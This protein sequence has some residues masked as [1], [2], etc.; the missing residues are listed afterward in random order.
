M[1]VYGHVSGLSR[2]VVHLPLRQPSISPCA[3]AIHD[4]DI[5]RGS[6]VLRSDAMR[7]DAMYCVCVACV[8]RMEY[9]RSRKVGRWNHGGK[10]ASEHARWSPAAKRDVRLLEIVGPSLSSERR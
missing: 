4:E 1:C 2:N 7:C 3:K 5:L 10:C 9:K 6:I 8:M